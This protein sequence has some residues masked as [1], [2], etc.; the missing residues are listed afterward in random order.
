MNIRLSLL[1]QLYW[2]IYLLDLAFFQFGIQPDFYIF[3]RIAKA[4][5]CAIL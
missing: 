3:G 4:D 2:T 5:A 1:R